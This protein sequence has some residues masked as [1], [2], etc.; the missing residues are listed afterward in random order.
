MIETVGKPK[1]NKVMEILAEVTGGKS[2]KA[3]KYTL[4]HAERP[5]VDYGDSEIIWNEERRLPRIK[6]T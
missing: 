4:D 5:S 1:R 3:H 2:Y 6:P